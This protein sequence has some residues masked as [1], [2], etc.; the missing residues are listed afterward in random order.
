MP[1]SK[2]A[3]LYVVRNKKRTTLLFLLLVVLMAISQLG[4]AL[5]AASGEAVKNL[6]SSIGG[7]ITIQTAMD[8]PENTDDALL[9]QV[10][11][12]D[13]VSKYNGVD[14]YYM[15]TEGLELIPG[16]Y[17]GTGMVGEFVPKFVACTDSSL[18]ERFVGASFLLAEGR[19]ITEDDLHKA[20]VSQELAQR[21]ELSLGD[22]IHASV[23]EGVAGWQPE[24]YGT[25]VGFE[26]VGIY[27][28][29]RNEPSDPTTPESELQENMIF[30]D[31]STAKELYAL[32]FPDRPAESFVYSLGI[33]LFLDDP[34]LMEQT[35]TDLLAQPYADWDNYV[36]SQN[37]TR[38]QS[39][40][41]S[42]QKAETLS[43]AASGYFGAQHRHLGADP[44]DVDTRA[45]DRGRHP[46]LAGHFPKS[47]HPAD[48]TGELYD[49]SARIRSIP[50]CQPR[51]V[52]HY[53][54]ADRRHAAGYSAGELYQSDAC[55]FCTDRR[56]NCHLY[57][58]T[59]G[60]NFDHAEKAERYPDRSQFIT[61]KTEWRRSVC[62]YWRQR[63]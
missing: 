51:A 7:Y 4:L 62:R 22:T 47:D 53:W 34:A 18:H 46:D 26:I 28:I 32:K 17:R 52:R 13:N 39:A 20:M 23:V 33:F 11:T 55:G 30:T 42:I 43:R 15:Y 21:N 31:I 49:W 58:S 9:Q 27:Q 40:A 10:R 29:A 14:P 25:E 44:A 41:A 12:L 8:S 60:I 24:Q 2:R 57:C 16:S 1:T 63:I 50:A 38:Y 36:I 56:R 3:W 19:H 35:A 54:E 37:D 45:H 5:H 61:C 6:R 48:H 59:A